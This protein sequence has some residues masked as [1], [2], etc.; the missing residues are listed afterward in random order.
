LATE[1]L[2]KGIFHFCHCFASIVTFISTSSS[3]AVAAASINSST[4]NAPAN[5]FQATQ[6]SFTKEGNGTDFVLQNKYKVVDTHNSH[7]TNSNAE[8][9]NRVF[10]KII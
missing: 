7:S 8:V 3:A 1:A 10:D 2:K 5:E 9:N 4:I 6:Y